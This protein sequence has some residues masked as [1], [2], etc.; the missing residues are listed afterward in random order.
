MFF[1]SIAFVEF[2]NKT[3]AKKVLQKK[4]GAKIQ[5]RLLIVNSVGDKKDT[6]AEDTKGKPLDIKYG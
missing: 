2:K 6:K 1:N 3:I 4:Q 5:D